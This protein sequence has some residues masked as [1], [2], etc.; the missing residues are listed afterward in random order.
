VLVPLGAC[1][2]LLANVKFT[3]VVYALALGAGIAGLFWLRG[4]RLE[5]GRY[6]VAGAFAAFIGMALVGYQPYVTNF[7]LHGNSFYPVLG[8]DEAAASAMAGQFDIW[9]PP[10]FMAMGRVEKLARSLLAES[11][12]AE[13]MP[14][15]RKPFT[16][17]RHWRCTKY[18]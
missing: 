8:S 1:V 9:A 4:A 12:G 15:N 5:A 10:E 7:R 17:G 6:A 3:G 14:S 16:R 11:G 13:S 2:V 18:S